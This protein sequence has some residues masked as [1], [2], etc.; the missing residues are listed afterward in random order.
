[1]CRLWR[2][3]QLTDRLHTPVT[4]ALNGLND[5]KDVVHVVT[6]EFLSCFHNSVK[7]Y[8]WFKIGHCQ[9][10]KCRGIADVPVPVTPELLIEVRLMAV[11]IAKGCLALNPVHDVTLHSFLNTNS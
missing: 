3:I 6:C 2:T 9:T 7:K 8:M 4:G 1:M 11:V 10:L 5:L